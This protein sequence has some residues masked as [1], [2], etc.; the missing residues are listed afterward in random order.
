MLAISAMTE[1]DACSTSVAGCP[2]FA[3]RFWALTWAQK[4]S[5][6]GQT[7]SIPFNLLPLAV[8]TILSSPYRHHVV[9]HVER[10]PYFSR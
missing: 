8:M 9:F 4:Y 2:R 10:L 3:P 6:R 5:S 1:P 7:Q